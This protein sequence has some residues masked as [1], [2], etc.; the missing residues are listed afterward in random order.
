[1]AMKGFVSYAHED[2]AMCR[3]FRAHLAALQ[4]A[5]A[6]EPWTDHE[7]RTGSQWEARMAAAIAAA[8]VFVLLVS[9]YFIESDYVWD[10]EIPAIQRQRAERGALVLPVVLIPCSWQTV[11]SSLHAAPTDNGRVRPVSEWRPQRNG[12]DCAREQMMTAVEG[13]F[14]IPRA[15]VRW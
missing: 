14:G 8:E 3:Q 12:Y 9:P 11:A 5:F 13:H 2:H 6:L 15:G 1:M 10:T 4:R 7:I